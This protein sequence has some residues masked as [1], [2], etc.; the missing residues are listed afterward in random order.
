MLKNILFS[1]IVIFFFTISLSAIA[2]SPQNSPAINTPATEPFIIPDDDPIVAMLDSLALLKV[3]R[4]IERQNQLVSP[5]NNLPSDFIPKFCDST[6]TARIAK[7]NIYSPIEFVHNSVVDAFIGLYAYRRRDLTER[8]MG[9]AKLYFPIFEEQL[10]KHN[11][12]LEL[13]YLAVIE[14]ALNPVARSRVGATGL[15]QFMYATGK[16]YGLQVNS[17]VDDRKD[18][19]RS[20]I[21]AAQYLRDLHKIYDDWALAL[22]AYNAGPGTVNRAIRRAGGVKDFWRIRPFL[23]RETQNFFPAFIAVAYVMK[24]AAYHNLFPQPPIFTDLDIDTIKV[25]E[26]LS[27]RVVSDM[28]DIPL[29]HLRYLNPTFRLNIIP[30]N[31]QNPYFLR[32]PRDFT[33][34]FIALEDSIYN[35]RSPDQVRQQ[36][37]AARVEETTTH[38]VRS[39][40]VL[41]SIARRY[42]T[43]VGEIQR[44]NNLRG[45]LIRPGQRLIV[46]AP[47]RPSTQIA[48]TANTHQVR[49]GETLGIIAARYR[50]TVNE[51]RLWN[52]LQGTT[53]YAGQNLIVRRPQNIESHNYNK[54]NAGEEL[55]KNNQ[56]KTAESILTR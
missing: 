49:R 6:Y 48:T 12:P 54:E 36:E 5:P 10:D 47:A 45:T 32:I 26:Q 1:G 31:P 40:D 22:S 7:M 35:F 21:A 2:Q 4:N 11:L 9:L 24:H 52:N 14:S 43:T 19:Y 53:I 29:D 44:L 46:R 41:G 23:P 28:L 38:V 56:N 34:R 39:G 51:L 42:G 30:H 20:T 33:G 13:K 3:F 15:W 25:R 55:N 27:L 17:F 37:L 50:V 16:M 18:V 8:V